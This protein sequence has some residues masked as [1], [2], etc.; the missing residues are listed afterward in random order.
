MM[1]AGGCPSGDLTCHP[2]PRSTLCAPPCTTSLELAFVDSSG[3]S[4]KRRT[5]ATSKGQ[6]VDASSFDFE[7]DYRRYELENEEDDSYATSRFGTKSYW[8]LM[9]AGGGDFQSDEYSW[10]YGMEVIKPYLDEYVAADEK[11]S[12][13]I[14][15]PGCGNDP[16]LLDLYNNGYRCLFGFDYSAEAIER[17]RDLMEYLPSDAVD[18]MDLRTLDARKLP[19]EWN[20]KFDV[21]LEKGVLDAIYLSGDGNFER[22]VK[23]LGRVVK[24]DGLCYSITGVVPDEVR[25]EGFDSDNWKCLRDGTD[26]L[27]AGCFIFKRQ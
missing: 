10:Y 18:A 9:Y 23:E 3:W 2:C 13:S 1:G 8:D 15:V 5:S 16:L 17:Q 26:D 7:R 12:L 22:S 21:I 25:M 24:P 6:F 27:K 19:D 4:P 11:S 14:L 20:K